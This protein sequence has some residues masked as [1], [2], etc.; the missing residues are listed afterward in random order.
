[1]SRRK[2]RRYFRHGLLPQLFVFEAVAR[3]GSVTRAAAELHLAQP[4]VS[5]QLKKLAA[6]LEVRL[7]TQRGRELQLTGAGHALREVCEELIGC[8]GRAEERLAVWRTP[9]LEPLLLAA[10]PEAQAVAARL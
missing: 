3:L 10:E 8:L 4:T 7:F 6:A 5:V 2:L 9:R 1:M